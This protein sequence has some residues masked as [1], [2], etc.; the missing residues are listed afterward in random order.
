MG[1]RLNA[2]VCV[3]QAKGHVHKSNY[4][5]AH[6]TCNSMHVMKQYQRRKYYAFGAVASVWT[7]AV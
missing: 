7:A 1:A 3:H 5:Q 4:N 2:H 6:Y